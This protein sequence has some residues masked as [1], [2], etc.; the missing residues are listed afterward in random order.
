MNSIRVYKNLLRNFVFAYLLLLEGYDQGVL[1][2][3]PIIGIFIEKCKVA[4]WRRS[5]WRIPLV[6]RAIPLEQFASAIHP[7]Q[8]FLKKTYKHGALQKELIIAPLIEQFQ[9]AIMTKFY[10]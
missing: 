2:K 7:N 5:Y 3:K 4:T 1:Q 9:T 6:L 8:P 10:W